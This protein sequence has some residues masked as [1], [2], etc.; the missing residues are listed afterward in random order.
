[1]EKVL[2]DY[3]NGQFH[4]EAGSLEF[5]C[6]RLELTIQ[7]NKTAEGSFTVWCNP[8][9]PVRGYVV[10]DNRR[11]QCPTAYFE[12][13]TAQIE[14]LF[15]GT[16]LE[17]G[18]VLKGEIS[19]ISSQGEYY[20]P[21]VV[22]VEYFKMESSLGVVKNLFHFANLAKTN[23]EEAV[24][25]FYRSDFREIFKGNDAQYLTVWQGFQT[26]HLSPGNVE[27]FLLE[28][29]KKQ[30][31]EYITEKTEIF[32]KDPNGVIEDCV[33]I[34]K[35]GWGYTCLQIKTDGDFLSCRKSTLTENDFL[36]NSCSL[37]YY[38]DADKLHAGNNYGGIVL[39]NAYT[40]ISISVTVTKHKEQKQPARARRQKQYYTLHLMEYYLAMRMDKISS[41]TWQKKT[42][43]LLGEWSSIDHKNVVCQLFLAQL[44]MAQERYNEARWIL[45][46]AADIRSKAVEDVELYCYY[47]YL[48][49]LDMKEKTQIR[50]VA[51]KIAQIY[52]QY[53]GRWR[54]AW[55][56]MY[57]DEE[58]AKS[59]S[60]KWMLLEELF[61]QNCTSPLIYLEAVSAIED[62]PTLLMKLHDFELQVL[63]FAAKNGLLSEEIIRQ[64]HYAVSRVREYIPQLHVILTA[65]YEQ[66]QDDETLQAICTHLIKGSQ[67]QPQHFEWYRLGVERELHITRLYEY[68][69][70]SVDENYLGE[71][72]KRVLLYFVYK[73][74]LTWRQKAYLYAY[75]VRHEA[76]Y[77]ELYRTYLPDMEQF[78]QEQLQKQHVNKH[79]IYLYKKLLTREMLH[80]YANEIMPLLFTK[81]IHTDNPHMKRVIVRYEKKVTESSY[82]LTDGETYVPL[83]GEEYKLFL[84]DEDKNRYRAGIEY[85]TTRLLSAGAAIRE[86]QPYVSGYLEFDL[87]VCCGNRHYLSVEEENEANYRRLSESAEI[88]RGFRC[89]LQTQLVEYY[90]REDKMFL[91]DDLLEKLIPAHFSKRDRAALIRYLALREKYDRA[92]EW[93][94]RYGAEEVDV[95]TMLRLCARMLKEGGL[96]GRPQMGEIAWAVFQKGK[97][98]EAVLLYLMNYFRGSTRQMRNIW[99]A[100]RDFD[101]DTREFTERMLVQMLFA[102]TF[103]AEKTEI[104]LEYVKQG[105]R[106]EIEEA[107]LAGMSFEYFVKNRVM[108]KEIWQ[109]V[110]RIQSGG[111]ELPDIVGLAYLKWLSQRKEEL[112]QQQ[113]ETAADLL[114]QQ[115]HKKRVFAFFKEFQDIAQVHNLFQDKT[116]LEYQ[117]RPDSRVILHYLTEGE[118][119][120]KDEYYKE[121]MKHMYGGIFVKTFVL[122]FGEN[123]QYYI[124]EENDGKEQLTESGTLT[125]SEMGREH[126]DSRYSVLNDIVTALTLQDYETAD[127]MLREYGQTEAAVQKLFKL[128]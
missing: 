94:E 103:V 81:R 28:I 65:C 59:P 20:L 42:E 121:E 123:L 48:N 41:Q 37:Q 96:Y 31:I 70:M 118:L 17:E 128:R 67:T 46:N 86:A 22:T 9:R 78:I 95:K 90:F 2:E 79:L 97:Y 33:R 24:S 74:S 66:M 25:L 5:S 43:L 72:P 10:S 26:P 99:K 14:Y 34:E 88:E 73:S 107:F 21:Y 89:S 114:K 77:P 84:E 4:Y 30:A 32:H 29:N 64:V 36:G 12:E 127:A 38:V 112:T 76:E 51:D 15:D 117:A 105:P 53:P 55:L 68:F 11:M 69:M 19:V 92:Y 106:P 110:A 35:N 27:E 91:L 126:A 102:D 61:Y 120:T 49:T 54:I 45:D 108:E 58:Y 57:V 83:L 63:Y 125:N 71:I 52:R 116:F 104:F 119:T 122:F 44:L 101:T 85:E 8:K 13:H 47:L 113:K 6:P 87:Y 60:R 100:A 56:L 18:E 82:A 40:S 75:I 39:E 109:E 1:M 124:T 7:K 62:N 111:W 115:M 98:N 23:W 93:V 16:G 50:T 3:R 80:K